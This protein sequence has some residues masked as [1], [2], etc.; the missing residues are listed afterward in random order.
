M[1]TTDTGI[2]TLY[3]AWAADVAAGRD[4]IMMAPT[5]DL[6]AELNQRARAD[7]IAAAGGNGD[8]QG[9]ALVMGNGDTDSAGDR[10]V[11]KKND[12]YLRLGGGTDFVQNNHRS[13][14]PPSTPTAP[15]T[16]SWTAVA[17]RRGCPPPTSPRAMSASGTRTPSPAARASPSAPPPANTAPAGTAP[18]TP[19]SPPG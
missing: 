2:D 10:I 13:P 6:V 17:P 19:C 5:L 4:S 11:T 14:S 1:T 12:R 3:A 18:R 15:W 8:D 7:R 9:R 16:P